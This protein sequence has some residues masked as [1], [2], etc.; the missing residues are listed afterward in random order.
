MVTPAVAEKD[1]FK[2][3]AAA[4]LL[5][6]RVEM[7]TPTATAYLLLIITHTAQVSM[8]T[9]CGMQLL[10]S[11]T[12]LVLSSTTAATCVFNTSFSAIAGVTI[13]CSSLGG[14]SPKALSQMV[15]QLLVVVE[16][17]LQPC[18][19]LKCILALRGIP[20]HSGLV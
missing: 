19:Y 7:F 15:S 10:T 13:S 14:I 3:H 16:G 8:M 12:A 1:I 2:T 5:D 9:C 20:P 11:R 17:V 6:I 18:R 4:V